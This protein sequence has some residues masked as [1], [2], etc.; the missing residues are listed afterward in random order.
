M[1]WSIQATGPMPLE[2]IHY[3]INLAVT[4][5]HHVLL[6][7]RTDNLIYVT[8][9]FFQDSPLGIK[10]V[11]IKDDMLGFFS[12]VLTYA[13]AADKLVQ[14]AHL[15]YLSSIMPRTNFL[16]MYKL[17]EN[18][19]EPYLKKQGDLFTLL[20]H[21]A[22][23]ENDY[24]HDKKTL[25]TVPDSKY[26]DI[27]NGKMVPKNKIVRDKIE[28]VYKFEGEDP[29]TVLL[30]NWINNLQTL[31]KDSLA[32]DLDALMWGQMGGLGERTE[33]VVDTERPVP[34]FEFRDLGSSTSATM[35]KDVKG[36]EDVF[37][38]LHMK[39][40]TLL[41]DFTPWW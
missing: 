23:W 38:A 13:K 29:E 2:G 26:C 39:F 10:A 31:E 33:F 27:V 40:K 37:L 15:K 25:Y 30:K 16:M 21:L 11:D 1:P 35:E 12:L 22:C 8:K 19:L 20:K 32:D 34:L 6:G 4:K 17:I 36:L 24:D 14:V 9:E 41:T 18:G 7:S 5:K 3:L 28:F